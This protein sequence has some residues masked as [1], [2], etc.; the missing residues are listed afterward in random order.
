M[1]LLAI[2]ARA[3]C[4]FH[5]RGSKLLFLDL[6]KVL[7]WLRTEPSFLVTDNLI[8]VAIKFSRPRLAR[9]ASLRDMALS[10]TKEQNAPQ[11]ASLH[12]L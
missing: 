3:V 2:S 1:I 12:L 9:P 11:G 4:L 6:I 7:F 10:V 5:G 8:A